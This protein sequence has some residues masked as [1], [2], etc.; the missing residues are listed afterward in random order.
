V[1]PTKSQ[2]EPIPPAGLAIQSNHQCSVTGTNPSAVGVYS[3]V[4][5]ALAILIDS[6][7]AS[8]DLLG[9]VPLQAHFGFKDPLVRVLLVHGQTAHRSF[10]LRRSRNLLGHSPYAQTGNLSVISCIRLS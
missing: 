9:R 2:G 8:I 3:V 10:P 1:P 4:F 5:S 6:A 7:F